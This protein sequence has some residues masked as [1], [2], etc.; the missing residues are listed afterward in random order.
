[1]TCRVVHGLKLTDAFEVRTGARQ[2]CLL[3]PV[4]FLLT[5]DWVMK[6]SKAQGQNSIQWTLW[7]QFDDVDYADD[8]A[9]LSHMRHQMQEKTSASRFGP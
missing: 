8:L 9:L 2:E 6:T 1:M 3:S 5:M 7:K 4:M